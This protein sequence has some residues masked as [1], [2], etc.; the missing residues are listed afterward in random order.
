MEGEDPLSLTPVAVAAAVV[1]VWFRE[2]ME[3]QELLERVLMVAAAA[4]VVVELSLWQLIVVMAQVVE[5]VVVVAAEEEPF[6]LL[7]LPPLFMGEAAGMAVVAAAADLLPLPLLR[8]PMEGS[9][10]AAVALLEVSPVE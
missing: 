3:P 4:A 7:L 6:L 2:L 9:A 5:P 1:R 10:V 8:T